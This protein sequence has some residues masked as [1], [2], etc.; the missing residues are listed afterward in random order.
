M[1]NILYRGS[2]VPSAYS[3]ATASGAGANRALTNLE[4]DQNFYALD[5]LKFDKAGGT[6]SGALTVNGTLTAALT[7]NA[8]TASTLLTTRTINGASF[9]G[10]ANISF[11]TDSVSE[12]TTNLYFTT[13]RARSSISATG[14]LSY[15]SSTGVMSFTQGNTDT[16]AEGASNL[17]FTTARARSSIS[18]SGALSYSSSTGVMSFTQGNTDTVAEGASNLYFTTARARAAVSVSGSLGYNSSTGVISYTTPSSLPASDVYTW[19]KA[20]SKPS[21]GTN[22]ISEVTNLFYTD[23]RA[24]ASIS[25]SGSL[26]YN[27][28]TGVI[29]YTTPS[30]LPASDVYTWAKAASK[31]SYSKSE[32]TGL[33]NTDTVQFTGLTIFAAGVNST[34]NIYGPNASSSNYSYLYNGTNDA[35]LSTLIFANTT[36]GT[37]GSFDNAG[38]FTAT[39][40]VTAYSDERL[41]TNWQDLPS[42]FVEQ[43]A[44]VKNGTYD[45]TDGDKVT[46]VGVSAQSLQKILPSAV[47]QGEEYLSVAYGNAALASAVELAKEMVSMRK[48]IEQ[49]SSKVEDLQNQLANK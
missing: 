15:S 24:R 14:S 35:T 21:Y 41:K 7:G 45:R 10:S 25:V 1:A 3:T 5:N 29:S 31:P 38:N 46:Q 12:G 13:A 49:L 48:I 23:A 8:Q 39:A 11:G 34:L 9:N 43:L 32:I 47:L 18:A 2:A 27:S 20:A 30:S 44:E 36:T 19:A 26:G 37:L 6:I 22:E 33:K 17:Y 4:I 28:S 42:N 16:V 40:N